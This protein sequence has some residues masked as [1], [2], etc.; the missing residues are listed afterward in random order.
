MIK[1]VN[2]KKRTIKERT[3]K[4]SVNKMLNTFNNI[5]D[6]LEFDDFDES[7][8]I[9]EA[10]DSHT[11]GITYRDKSKRTKQHM[12][13]ASDAYD[14]KMK[15]RKELGINF[16]DI[17]DVSMI[18]NRNVRESMRKR[19]RHKKLI[20]ESKVSGNFYAI[21]DIKMVWNGSQSD[22]GLIYDNKYFNYYDVEDALVSE[23]REYCEEN[24]INDP[25]DNRF[26][27][28]VKD[29]TDLVY[30][31]I[32]N[33]IDGGY[34]EDVEKVSSFGSFPAG[35]RVN[36]EFIY[37]ESTR[38][39][40]RKTFKMKEAHH[41]ELTPSYDSRK[42][43]YGKAHVV[44]DDDG[45]KILYSYD[46]PVCEIKDNKVKLL[47]QWDS[48]QTT[49]RHVKEFLQQNGFSVGSKSQL[50]KMYGNTVESY[51]KIRKIH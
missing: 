9:D 3:E 10:R 22:P 50:A 44:T 46:T 47:T 32:E 26:D 11:W 29:N 31:Y 30:Y 17:D 2:N 40:N 34:Y 13:G 19:S 24:N 28:W 18:E 38:K 8:D 23:Y 21:P 49:L 7:I 25:N 41:S 39:R 20:K 16:S 43:F 45:T 48:S 35:Y 36:D 12:V 51:R 6:D 33:L 37:G 42:S 15:A 1:R 5:I 27:N 4:G 14:A